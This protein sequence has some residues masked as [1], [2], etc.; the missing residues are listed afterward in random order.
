MI[1][2][3]GLVFEYA[4]GGFRLEI[5]MLEIPANRVTALLGPN[6]SGK[7]TLL[8]LLS[9]LLRPLEGT[10]TLGERPLQRVLESRGVGVLSQSFPPTT[11]LSARRWLQIAAKLRAAGS[12]TVEDCLDADLLE[13]ADRP[14]GKLSRGQSRRIGLALARLGAG[15]YLLLDEPAEALDPMALISFRSAILDARDSGKTVL[16]ASHI[17]SEVERVADC[18]IFLSR[19]QVLRQID[20]TTPETRERMTQVVVFRLAGPDL[21]AISGDA[22]VSSYRQDADGRVH[23]L[24]RGS[25]ADCSPILRRVLEVG[26]VI[27]SVSPLG[28]DLESLFREI[29][30]AESRDA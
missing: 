13:V 28:D 15:P 8:H 10:I 23:L 26:G 30:E 6:G 7:S 1:R 3:Q 18:V 11:R 24:L 21:A 27:D 25:A 5:P 2:M 19:G 16:I 12:P 14:F 22:A 9:G 20:R 17:L 4:G 29:V